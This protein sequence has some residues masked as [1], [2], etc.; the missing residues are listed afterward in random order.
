MCSLIAYVMQGKLDACKEV[1]EVSLTG[2]AL[3]SVSTNFYI[4]AIVVWIIKFSFFLCTLP[5]YALLTSPE[6]RVRSEWR[7]N[8]RRIMRCRNSEVYVTKSS[9]LTKSYVISE[10]I[11]PLFWWSITNLRLSAQV[12]LR[13]GL[14]E[15][16]CINNLWEVQ[17]KAVHCK[18]QKL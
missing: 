1:A 3:R 7:S 11:L 8:F 13:I 12:N 5:L 2:C 9:H 6:N 17:R 18:P 10:A 15:D 14:P 4:A 16:L